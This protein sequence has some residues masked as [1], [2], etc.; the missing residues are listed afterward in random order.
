MNL[1]DIV[2][3][4][5]FQYGPEDA[6]TKLLVVM[7]ANENGEILFFKTTAQPSKYRPDGQGCH[8]DASVFKFNDPA[9]GGFDKPTW[10]QYDPPI[11][12]TEREAKNKGAHVMFTLS[13]AD[14]RAITNCYKGCADMSTWAL[15]MCG[16]AP[17]PKAVG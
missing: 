3:W 17:P 10:V 1:G 8:S 4:P 16:N 9:Y 14:F 5:M 2:C 12:F 15:S 6:S 11:I 7:G 13:Q